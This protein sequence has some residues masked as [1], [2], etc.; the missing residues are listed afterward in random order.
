MALLSGERPISLRQVEDVLKQDSAVADYSSTIGLNFIDNYSQPNAAFLIVSLKPF[1]D[2]TAASQSA[3]AMI[4]GLGAKLRQVRGGIAVP[5]APPPIIG[6]GTGG[7]F[8]YVLQDTSGG[9]PTI[10]GAGI[11]WIAGGGKSGSEA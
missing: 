3:Q 2:R 6:L 8:S 7:G 5:L 1:E 11:A 10:T 9:S 4:A